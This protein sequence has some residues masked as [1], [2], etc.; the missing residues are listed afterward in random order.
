MPGGDEAQP[1]QPPFARLD[2]RFQHRTDGGTR[3]EV[4]EAHDGR[5]H[6]GAAAPRRLPRRGGDERRLA[7]RAQQR[8]AFAAVM[9][10]AFDEDAGADRMAAA[11]IDEVVVQ[12]V[13]VARRAPEMVVRVDNRQRR[14]ERRLVMQGEPF[15]PHGRMAQRRLVRW[16]DQPGPPPIGS[17]MR[18]GSVDTRRIEPMSGL[19][20]LS[21][22]GGRTAWQRW[23]SP[24]VDRAGGRVINCRHEGGDMASTEFP[25][26]AGKTA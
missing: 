6:L 15:G 21:I 13:G 7:E 9:R 25:C 1:A 19:R 24:G 10:V 5:R 17:P 22:P 23:R 4:G 20:R 26:A 3:G 8:I 12:Q 14:F 16:R 11:Q 2:L 18:A